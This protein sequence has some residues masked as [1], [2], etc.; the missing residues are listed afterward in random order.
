MVPEAACAIYPDATGSRCWGAS[1]GDSNIQGAWSKVAM[2][3]GF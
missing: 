3:E 1:P 2:C